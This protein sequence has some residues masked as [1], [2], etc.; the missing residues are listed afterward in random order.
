M[1]THANGIFEVKVTPQPPED[2]AGGAPIGRMLLDKQFHGDLEATSQG[3][4]LAAGTDVK[5]SAGYVALERV[6]GTLQGRSGTFVL[7]HSGTM[8]RGTPQLTITVVPDSG[9]GGLAGLAGSMTIEI[10]G[11][12]HSYGF[13]YTL[14]G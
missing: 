9:T 13:E 8:N 2:A 1:M 4:M 10:A 5:G 3:Q 14:G 7:Q 12:K 6:T 11:G